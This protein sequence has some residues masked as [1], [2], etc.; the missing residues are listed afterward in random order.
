MISGRSAEI[1][2][3]FSWMAKLVLLQSGHLFKGRAAAAKYA[4]APPNQHE[5]RMGYTGT[6]W[7]APWWRQTGD[8]C[9]TKET[10]FSITRITK[11]GAH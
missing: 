9:D 1:L 10:F 7:P 5:G 6:I 4:L 3:I 2:T 8:S 11:D